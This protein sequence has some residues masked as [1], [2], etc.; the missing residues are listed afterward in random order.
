[1]V[2]KTLDE[3]VADNVVRLRKD[4]RLTVESL[5]RL[6]GVKPHVVYDMQ[7][8]Q[9]GRPQRAF[10][11]T[12]L[13]A[14][15]GALNTTLFDLV[16]PPEGVQ[17]AGI[18]DFPGRMADSDS[19]FIYGPGEMVADAGPTG[20]DGLSWMLFGLP[21]EKTPDTRFRTQEYEK[22]MERLE[23]ALDAL[24]KTWGRKER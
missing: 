20:R 21:A 14:L 9:R 11:W 15:C 19:E 18:G 5:A 16:L 8:A 13:V 6:I 22:R 17:I 12:E 4:L 10:N 3:I 2:S 24:L 7:R 1:M 23:Q